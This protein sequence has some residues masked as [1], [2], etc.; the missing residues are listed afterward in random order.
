M[1]VGLT[2][3][4]ALLRD[5]LT[6]LLDRIYPFETRKERVASEAGFAEADWQELVDL[7]ITAA[8]FPEAMGGLGLGQSDLCVIQQGLGSHNLVSPYLS[9]VVLAGGLLA[10]AAPERAADL[11]GPVIAGRQHLAL[12][13]AERGSRYSLCHVTTRAERDG[14]GYRLEGRKTAVLWAQAAGRLLVSARSSGA[15]GERDGISLFLVDP[16][17]EGVSLRPYA[18]NDGHRAAE[19]FFSG[20]QLPA[21]SLLGQEDTALPLIE[22]ACDRAALALAAEA[23]G[24][25]LSLNAETLDYVRQRQQFGRPIGKFQV[26]QHACAYMSIQADTL[27]ATVFAAAQHADRQV[28][29]AT[30]RRLVSTSKAQAGWSGRFIG[31]TALQLHGGIGMS[32]DLPIG[33]F[34]KRLSAIRVLFGDPDYHVRRVKQLDAVA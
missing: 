9:S 20:V 15:A 13:Y 27:E 31:E 16:Q 32:A 28:D 10:Q 29:L 12:A 4:Q 5:S 34:L 21:D 24:C 33:H 25:C 3:D 2:E 8:P 1:L 22:A 26:V 23:L 6:R 19:V 17:A 30:Q 7:G 11:L 14:S 18:T